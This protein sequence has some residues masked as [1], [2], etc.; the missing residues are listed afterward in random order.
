MKKIAI[1]LLSAIAMGVRLGDQAESELP[2]DLQL[3]EA[4]EG[5]YADT[6]KFGF[7]LRRKKS[8]KKI[9]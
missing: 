7:Y 5:A 9:R 1:A 8:N 4:D 6:E 3:A 2:E